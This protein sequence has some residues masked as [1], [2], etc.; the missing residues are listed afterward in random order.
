MLYSFAKLRSGYPLFPAGVQ[1]LASKSGLAQT[2]AY[3]GEASP[4]TQDRAASAQAHRARA[5]RAAGG[6]RS[7]AT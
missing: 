1:A 3:A 2:Q 5:A 6:V 4:G 7:T